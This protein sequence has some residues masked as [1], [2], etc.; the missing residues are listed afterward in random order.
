MSVVL[1]DVTPPPLL[2]LLFFVVC[3]REQE[4]PLPTRIEMPGELHTSTSRC[5]C[6]PGVVDPSLPVLFFFVLSLCRV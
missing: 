4:I 2:L 6:A 5:V 1:D 3:A